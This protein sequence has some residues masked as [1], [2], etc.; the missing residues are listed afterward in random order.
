M[1]GVQ[2]PS[3]G[4]VTDINFFNSKF[5]TLFSK[6]QPFAIRESFLQ[7]VLDLIGNRL[8]GVLIRPPL[9]VYFL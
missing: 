6:F 1:L 5:I 3:R 8:S 7:T 4:K 9:C 2:L